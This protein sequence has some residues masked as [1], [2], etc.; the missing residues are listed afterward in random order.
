MPAGLRVHAV[1]L[2]ADVLPAHAHQHPSLDVDDAH[3]DAGH[4]VEVVHELLK[5]RGVD[6]VR[7]FERA[8]VAVG[9]EYALELPPHRPSGCVH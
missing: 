6:Q 7:Q 3:G 8:Q 9:R 1:E 2:G 5:G 4:R